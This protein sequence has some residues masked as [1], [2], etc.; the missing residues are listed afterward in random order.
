MIHARKNRIDYGEQLIPPDGYTLDRAIGTTY[1][2]DLETLM[3]LPV[4][5]F[6]SQTLEG[7]ISQIRYDMLDSIINAS[8]KITVFY[9][10]GQLKVP[11]NYHHLMA[12]WEKGIREVLMPNYSQSFHPKVWAIRYVKKGDVTIYRLLVTSRNMT[13]SRDWDVAFSTQGEVGEKE[14]RRNKPLI[15]FLE[16]LNENSK[17]KIDKTFMYDLL[18]VDFDLPDKFD[19]LEFQPIGVK[20][21]D[22]KMYANPI[23]KTKW[24]FAFLIIKKNCVASTPTSSNKSSR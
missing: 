19:K 22:K 9:Q 21:N 17:D 18:K 2:L 11:P 8:R 4:A 23:S 20:D 15:H 5:L 12:Y 6:Y 1:S 10:K 3:V 13:K 24:E 16:F 7:S 14:I